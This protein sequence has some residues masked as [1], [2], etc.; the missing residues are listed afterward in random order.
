MPFI[1]SNPPASRTGL[2]NLCPVGRSCSLEERQEFAKHDEEQGVRSAFKAELEKVT[3]EACDTDGDMF[4]A[5]FWPPW[6]PVCHGGSDL[7]RLLSHR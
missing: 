3:V 5:E 4:S 6:S 1:S 2:I 7:N